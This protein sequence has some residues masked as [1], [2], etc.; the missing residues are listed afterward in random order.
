MPRLREKTRPNGPEP[1]AVRICQRFVL[2][3]QSLSMYLSA[4]FPQRL[5]SS[6]VLLFAGVLS[7]K[8]ASFP[9]PATLP[10]HPG[11]PDALVMLDGRRVT[12]REQWFRE[13]RPEL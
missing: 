3:S 8:S 13:R 12:T 2:R 11:I 10:A 1:A 4:P 7:M 5:R 6:I 9:E